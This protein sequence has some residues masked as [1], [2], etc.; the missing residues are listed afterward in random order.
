MIKFQSFERT[1]K[2]GACK[3]RY[4]ID[5]LTVEYSGEF[6]VIIGVSNPS[7][8]HAILTPMADKDYSSKILAMV[9]EG[10]HAGKPMPID[11]FCIDAE[12]CGTVRRKE[13][14]E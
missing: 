4:L 1:C 10:N 9:E 5:G 3:G 13:K 8:A 11:V 6:A 2:C 7:L 14:G 12:K